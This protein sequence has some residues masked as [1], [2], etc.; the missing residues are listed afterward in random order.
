MSIRHLPTLS[1]IR[2][3]SRVIN[4]NVVNEADGTP[5]DI[6]GSKVYFTVS[7]SPTPTNDSTAALA[8]STSSHVDPVNGITR[9]A[10]TNSLTQN[11]P[12]GRL[13]YDVQVKDAQ[14]DISS[15]LVGSFMV[16]GDITRS[17]S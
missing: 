3:D 2:G 11:M 13:Y 16:Y 4:I 15:Q 6:S 10:L 7:A 9:L 5:V 12:T 8:V 1:Y 14:G 17:V